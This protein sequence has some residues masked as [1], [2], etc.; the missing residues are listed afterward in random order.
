MIYCVTIQKIVREHED[1]GRRHLGKTKK[2][3]FPFVFLSVCTTFV[4]TIT[5]LEK[6]T[7]KLY[8]NNNYY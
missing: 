5:I 1:A 4:G 3:C 8:G 6:Q 7:T 2:K